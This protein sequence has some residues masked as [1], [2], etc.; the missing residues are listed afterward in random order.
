MK[1]NFL[2]GV[3]LHLGIIADDFMIP[4]MPTINHFKRR[5]RGADPACTRPVSKHH[6][7]NAVIGD[8]SNL[9]KSVRCG[10]WKRIK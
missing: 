5:V 2:V 1:N 9:N 7:T 10:P 8:A 3:K 4:K 6:W